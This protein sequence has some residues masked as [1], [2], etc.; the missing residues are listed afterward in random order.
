MT[1]HWMRLFLSHGENHYTPAL[2][3]T[4]NYALHAKHPDHFSIPVD[5]F[6][7]YMEDPSIH[8]AHPDC[9]GIRT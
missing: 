3:L 5:H 8:R 1:C 6:Y 9:Y 7:F 2:S 4:I